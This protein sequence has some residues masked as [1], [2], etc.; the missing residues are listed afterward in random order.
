ML[1]PISGFLTEDHKYLIGEMINQKDSCT[2]EE[3]IED[4][5][6]FL[7]GKDKE[8][9]KYI[10]DCIKELKELKESLEYFDP[11]ITPYNINELTQFMDYC[12]YASHL[13]EYI[14]EMKKLMKVTKRKQNEDTIYCPF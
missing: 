7:R 8:M 1:S 2:R 14:N 12:H 6:R 10:G 4:E 9:E 5:L 3:W 13:K 11:N